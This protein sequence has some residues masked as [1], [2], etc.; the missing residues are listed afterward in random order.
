V[1]FPFAE[2]AQTLMAAAG[3]VWLFRAERGL[4]LREPEFHEAEVR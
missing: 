4:G 2:N 1:R 3:L